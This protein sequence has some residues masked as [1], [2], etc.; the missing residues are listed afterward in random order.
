MPRVIR[1]NRDGDGQA[2]RT[3]MA[4]LGRLGCLGASLTEQGLPGVSSVAYGLIAHEL[5]RVD[6]AYRSSWS[7]QSSLV[8]LPIAKFGSEQQQAK[9]LPELAKGNLVGCFGLTEPNHGSDPA[10]METRA[11]RRQDGHWVL[12]GSK[13]WIT[14]SP[15][16]DVMVVWARVEE[17]GKIRGFLL[18]RG[19]KGLETPTIEGKLSLRASATGMI[20]MD[21]VVVDESCVLP[22]VEGL[23]GP[24]TCL[25]SA[26]FGIAWGV[27]GSAEFCVDKATEYSLERSQ[28]GSPL[29]ANQLIQKKLADSVTEINLGLNGVLSAG[30]LKDQGRLGPEA[31]SMLKRNSCGKALRI[32]REMRDVLGA[33][34]V[35]DEY[36]VMRHAMNL[37]S[38]NTYEGTHDIHALILGRFITGIEAFT[39]GN[40]NPG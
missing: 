36:H 6:S 19:M 24:F 1:D 21:D 33:N 20:V 12:S 38:V 28:F 22:G 4:D 39:R 31:I 34:G 15:I 30:R 2:G 23:R 18:E 7:V 16:A 29:A 13:T 11:R 10:G 9:W 3:V 8:M 25:N 27:L 14:N 35:S 32:A 40:V 37:E 17:T 5:E 26:R